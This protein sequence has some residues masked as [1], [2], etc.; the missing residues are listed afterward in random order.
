MKNKFTVL[1]LILFN[2]CHFDFAQS[3]KQSYRPKYHY[4]PPKNWVNDPNGLV[5]LDGEYHLFTQYNPYGTKWGHM[6]WGH[7]VSNDLQ[8]WQALPIAM[9]EFMNPD[10]S[11]TMLFSGCAVVDSLN[12]SGFFRK[13]FKKGLVAIFTSHVHKNLKEIAQH[14]SL[15]FSADKGRSWKKYEQNPVLD[16]G[17][18]NFRDPNVI[19]YPERKVWIMT[20]VKPL[21]YTAQFYESSNLKSWK[22]LSEFGNR[23]DISKIWE[24]PSLTKIPIENSQE[25]KWMLTI[26]SGHSQTNFVGVQYFI[27]DFDGKN[28]KAQNQ[29]EPFFMDA[30]K[31]FYAPIPYYNLPKKYKKPVMIAWANNW[32]YANDIP[33]E[34]FRGAYSVPRELSVYNENNTFKLRQLP[35]QLKNIEQKSIVI[36][37]KNSQI[38]IPSFKSNSYILNMKI[39]LENRQGFKLEL[40]K[41]DDE[42]AILSYDLLTETLSFDRNNS[43]ITNFNPAFASVETM[44]VKVLNNQLELKILV[45]NSL[46]EIFANNGKATLSDLV[47]PTKNISSVNFSWK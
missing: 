32:T 41:N 30:G 8:N 5:Y 43:G 26:S 28:F 17:L 36:Y 45:D 38:N 23:G 14:Q 27:G 20:V 40:L 10:S 1:I 18:K 6:S 12:T 42:T 29:N 16:L 22:L 13:G 31:D 25:F 47:F 44:K 2:F 11:Q 34:G 7:A 4:S 19:W 33:T 46:V 9:E 39:I 37:E 35:I 21:E 3:N 15:M 24:C